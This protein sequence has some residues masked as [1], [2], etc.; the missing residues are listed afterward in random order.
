[1]GIITIDGVRRV[2][3]AVAVDMVEA[4]VDGEVP[5]AEV[6]AGVALLQ[7]DGADLLVAAMEVLLEVDGEARPVEDG[8]DLL[9]ADMVVDLVMISPL[10]ILCDLRSNPQSFH[11]M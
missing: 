10:L 8:A 6:E 4:E 11:L 7:A 2:V 9:V 5:R 1:M 3:A